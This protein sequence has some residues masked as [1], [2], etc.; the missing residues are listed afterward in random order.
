MQVVNLRQ[1]GNQDVLGFGSASIAKAGCMLVCFT[2]A[3]NALNG[4]RFSPS[5]LNTRLKAANAFASSSLITEKVAKNLGLV[6][7]RTHPQPLEVFDALNDGQLVMLGVDYKSGH[8]SGFSEADHF[9]LAHSIVQDS[10]GHEVIIAADP[11][12]GHDVYFSV[13]QF[14]ERK[15]PVEL[16]ACR[17]TPGNLVWKVREALYLSVPTV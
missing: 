17:P 16:L 1:S 5:L 3:S 12:T 11:A 6:I 15:Q 9:V 10:D 14:I 4:T 13:E 7:K 2:M 8:S